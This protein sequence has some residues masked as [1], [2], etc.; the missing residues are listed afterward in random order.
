[1]AL[2]DDCQIHRAALADVE[3][4]LLDATT[5]GDA[6]DEVLHV[7]ATGGDRQS[8]VLGTER[9]NCL[10]VEPV[11]IRPG[12]PIDIVGCLE[13]GVGLTHWL[14]VF[15]ISVGHRAA[16]H[17]PDVG[18]RAVIEGRQRRPGVGRLD[19]A[20]VGA[21]AL[22]DVVIR[23][24]RSGGAHGRRRGLLQPEVVQQPLVDLRGGEVVARGVVR[25]GML[26]RRTH[27][28]SRCHRNSNAA[29]YGAPSI[30]DG[31]V[32]AGRS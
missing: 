32:H 29:A 24:A 22:T 6:V 9:R 12:E 30:R 19:V 27:T 18:R 23:V 20:N 26:E 1:M 5:E 31:P 8:R 14:R 13:R 15:P 17:A 28:I 2:L 4:H 21:E 11:R 16:A 10:V 25:L 3:Q 7:H